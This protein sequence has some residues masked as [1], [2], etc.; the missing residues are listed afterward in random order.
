MAHN[1]LKE[2]NR[3]RRAIIQQK[4]EPECAVQLKYDGC[5]QSQTMGDLNS[6]SD[7]PLTSP[8]S[9]VIGQQ[10]TTDDNSVTS[11]E[12]D[13]DYLAEIVKTRIVEAFQECFVKIPVSV[14]NTVFPTS[15]SSR[16]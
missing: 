16:C 14:N 4:Q 7:G 9:D 11:S 6:N 2:D 12:D 8:P 15:Y 1:K 10:Q 13:S 5:D 3:K